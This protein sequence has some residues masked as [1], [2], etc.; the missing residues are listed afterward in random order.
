MGR[1]PLEGPVVT[2]RGSRGSAKKGT[3]GRP[4]DGIFVADFSRVLAGPLCTQLLA[5]NGARIIKVEEP[6]RG[7]E[8]RRWGPPFVGGISAYFLSI[9]RSKESLTLNLKSEE[10]GAVARELMARA[11]VVVD[12]FLD[13]QKRA[14]GFP[15]PRSINPRAVHC[16]I[17]GYDADTPE[18]EV[19]GYDLLAQAGSGLMAITGEAEGD[20]MKVGVALSDVLTAH[21]AFGAICAA[22]VKG[23]GASIEVSLFGATV[24]SLVNVAQSALVTRADARRYGNAHASIVPYQLFHGSD[25]PFAIGVGTDRHFQLLCT[26]VLGNEAPAGDP[27]FATNA[28]RVEHREELIATLES[29]FRT[30]KASVWVQRCRRAA[31]PASLVRGVREALR[32]DGGRALVDTV[33]HPELGAYEALRNPVRVDGKR[34]AAG[35]AP[36]ALGEHTDRILRELGYK[37]GEIKGLRARGVV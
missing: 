1:Q 35:T 36:P 11:D 2:A 3:A 17:R 21:Y 31:I 29:V 20:P 27:R 14:L 19:P 25:R 32:T 15:D 7:D 26:G 34:R 28:Q 5:D 4:L 12:N 13:A 8:T 16:T 33:E 22:L 18:G 37:I 30:K 10:G 24:A 23:H 9:N 6:G